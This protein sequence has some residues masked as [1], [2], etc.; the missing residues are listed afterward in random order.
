MYPYESFLQE[1][2]QILQNLSDDFAYYLLYLDFTDF[3]MVNHFYGM[4]A[5][6]SLLRAMEEALKRDPQVRTCVNIFSDQFLCLIQTE[7]DVDVEKI[8]ISYQQR[9][10][11]FL[12]E[13]GTNYPLCTL[14][15]SCG[16]C[17]VTGGNI[18][19][20]VDGANLARKEA[21]RRG[22]LR[23]F[24]YS[25]AMQKQMT[26]QYELER[27]VNDSLREERFLFYLQPKVD[28]ETGRTIGAEALARRVGRDGSIIYPDA[29][30]SVMEA[31]GSIVEPGY[32]DLQEG[33]CLPGR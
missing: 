12:E 5:G 2:N 25:D 31:N 7:K 26:D 10:R 8:I 27:A 17:K 18:K 28:L 14:K 6:D 15:L 23:A 22:S 32:A 21:K 19:Y 24:P 4:E 3:Q 13:Q 20:A 33:V 9:S 16:I 29:F 30:L 11:L 1:S